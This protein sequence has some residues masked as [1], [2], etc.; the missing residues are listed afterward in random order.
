MGH[1]R[2]Q[3]CPVERPHRAHLASAG[4][5]PN[6]HDD[7]EAAAE[8]RKGQRPDAAG[9]PDR[10]KVPAPD[11]PEAARAR[12]MADK[13]QAVVAPRSAVCSSSAP[14]LWPSGQDALRASANQPKPFNSYA[15]IVS[16]GGPLRPRSHAG[17]P[18]AVRVSRPRSLGYVHNY[19][20]RTRDS[21]SRQRIVQ[22][23]TQLTPNIQQ[24]LHL[25]RSF[26]YLHYVIRLG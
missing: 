26:R 16:A 13:F 22:F 11:A 24:I 10:R 25:F 8:R 9:S 4:D 2:P 15:A 3:S 17:Y 5:G 7:P 21:A 6:N 18:P 14:D 23:D 19:C 12:R 1:T 20:G